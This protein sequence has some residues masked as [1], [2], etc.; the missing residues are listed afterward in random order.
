MKKR[1]LA[2][3]MA[4]AMTMSLTACGSD[5]GTKD[6]SSNKQQSSENNQS[7][8]DNNVSSGPID[9]RL[10]GA[11]EDQ[12]LLA[13]RV[14]AFKAA[15]P[16]QT[17][18]IEIGVESESTAKDTVLTDIEAA[19]DVFS[20][21]DDQLADLVD[22]GA[23]LA[24]DESMD[25][26]LQTYANKS[27]DDVKAANVDVS[28]D[29]ATATKDGKLY[30]FPMSAD[31][32][33]F[34]FYDS[35]VFTE[36]DVQTW[37]GLLAA[38]KKNGGGRKVGMTFASGWYNAGFFYGAGFTTDRNEDGTTAIDWNGTSPSGVTGVQVTQA[39][40]DI[41]S[42]SAFQPMADN[43]GSNLIAS[44]K[45]CAAVSGTWD[46][47]AV[48]KVFKKGYAATKLP[49]YTVGDQQIQTGSVGG[50]KLVGVN[51]HSKNSG[52]AVLL[53]EYL[54]NEESQI[55]RFEAREIGP[56]NKNAQ[57]T[58]AVQENVALAAILQQSEFASIQR[59]G[60]K[61]WDPTKTFGE[62][63]AQGKINSDDASVQAALDDLIAGVTA[64]LE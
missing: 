36:E 43:E 40:I 27:L 61:Y 6:S 55:A 53:A 58:D 8:A 59:T 33:Y 11:E 45:L 4:M 12:D 10:W 25:Q 14:E 37:D 64:P 21:A 7:D 46:A 34:L 13:E 49:T 30:A 16:D 17:F 51:A 42:N 28:I 31:N 1:F 24:I 20:F 63:I 23:L 2:M 5:S 48:K 9:L 52:W 38:A 35:T 22:A 44:G 26:V 57:A 41:A 32:G 29:A 54:T 19:A 47:K 50:S 56:S 60:G 15:Y 3:A 18:N 62:K 39:M